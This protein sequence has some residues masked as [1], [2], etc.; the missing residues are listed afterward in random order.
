MYDMLKREISKGGYKLDEMI[1]R[2]SVLYGA[3]QF[4]E[5]SFHE[6]MEAASANVNPDAGFDTLSAFKAVNEKLEALEK[7]ILELELRER[8][9]G[10]EEAPDTEQPE[11]EDVTIPTYEEWQPWNGIPG[12]GY[13]KGT[14]VKHLGKFY[15]S[16]FVG[17]NVWEPGLIGTET[18]WIE[19]KDIEG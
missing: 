8:N 14:I 4:D 15:E 1:R 3:K 11:G 18:L 13:K 12:S 9:E 10:T 2:I 6:L 7:R 16:N 5:T 19:R 17:L